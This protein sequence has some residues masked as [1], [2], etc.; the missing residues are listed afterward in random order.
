MGLGRFKV[1]VSGSLM[2]ENQTDKKWTMIW[3]LD[4]FYRAYEAWPWSSIYI[5]SIDVD[6]QQSYPF[7]SLWGC[8][9][10]Y[11]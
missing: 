3:K 6:I 5:P 10:R 11:K 4:F 7:Q 2:A 1:R 9:H 8:K